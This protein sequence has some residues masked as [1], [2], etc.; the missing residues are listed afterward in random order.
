MKCS[1]LQ[2]SR[3]CIKFVSEVF[4]EFSIEEFLNYQDERGDEVNGKLDL[5]FFEN[6]VL[7]IIDLKTGKELNK[8]YLDYQL[9]SY[10]YLYCQ[11]H[12]IKPS[13]IIGIGLG[14]KD[15]YK[16]DFNLKQAEKKFYE[17]LNAKEQM[18]K[19][20][21]EKKVVAVSNY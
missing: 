2:T 11:K 9:K 3:K 21:E 7:Y 10:A 12:K 15:I 4:P 8:N 19:E 14:T 16:I 17:L 20:L 18:L 13:K 6:N 1:I 5:A